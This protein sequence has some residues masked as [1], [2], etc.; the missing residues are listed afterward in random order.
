VALPGGLARPEGPE[1]AIP[2]LKVEGIE[3]LVA[4]LMAA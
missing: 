1:R 3:A 2:T 4:V